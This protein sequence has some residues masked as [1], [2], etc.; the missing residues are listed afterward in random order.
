MRR[1]LKHLWPHVLC[2]LHVIGQCHAAALT[3]L[4]PQPRNNY[5]LVL[6]IWWKTPRCETINV[7]DGLGRR[8]PWQGSDWPEDGL[9]TSLDRIQG[10]QCMAK[11]REYIEQFRK[12]CKV[13][14]KVSSRESGKLSLKVDI[15]FW[16][17]LESSFQIL[18]EFWK[19]TYQKVDCRK[20]KFFRYC[21]GTLYYPLKLIW[22]K[23]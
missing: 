6:P 2:Y 3:W 8:N 17:F 7:S 19:V 15:I 13:F 10:L 4:L 23:Y 22:N 12:V 9:H 21:S 5:P 18:S 20:S 14:W 1:I 11:F 16:E